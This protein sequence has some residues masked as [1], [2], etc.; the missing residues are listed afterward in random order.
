VIT[1]YVVD[2]ELLLKAL[3]PVVSLVTLM[4]A[5]SK[6]SKLF[7]WLVHGSTHPLPNNAG[8]IHT[9]AIIIANTGR[10]SATNIRIHHHNMPPS[11]NMHPPVPYT[12]Q[13][14]TGGT[15]I[16]IDRIVPHQQIQISYLY[17]P[18]LIWRDIGAIVS[19]D[20]GYAKEIAVAPTRQFPAI[21][22][23]AFAVLG[24][25]GLSTVIYYVMKLIRIAIVG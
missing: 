20:D 2:W 15:S 6:R 18:P 25:L 10:K 24:F 1:E 5:E 17:A 21:V 7:V 3:A 13:A 19:S 14:Y 23:A 11:I 8:S 4:V 22:N 16:N 9:H 12:T